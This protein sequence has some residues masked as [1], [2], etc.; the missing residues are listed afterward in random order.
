MRHSH[1][2][3]VVALSVCRSCYPCTAISRT[4]CTYCLFYLK[5][6]WNRSSKYTEST[7]SCIKR[8][9][10][11]KNPASF[12][13]KDKG[14][15]LNRKVPFLRSK[16]NSWFGFFILT[17]KELRQE[18]KNWKW[19]MFCFSA[20]LHLLGLNVWISK[21]TFQILFLALLSSAKLS[22]IECRLNWFISEIWLYVFPPDYIAEKLL[23]KQS[24]ARMA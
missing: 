7:F 22:Y 12:Q 2:Q 14:H 24:E 15:N 5:G 8:L 4:A 9:A 17:T 10:E 6:I 20:V 11:E 1:E 13:K 16:T 3:T 18:Q 21:G 19:S 23:E